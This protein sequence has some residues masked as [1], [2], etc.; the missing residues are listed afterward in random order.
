MLRRILYFFLLLLSSYACTKIAQKAKSRSWENET[1]QLFLLFFCWSGFMTHKLLMTDIHC[2]HFLRTFESF[3]LIGVKE[4]CGAVVKLENYQHM[5]NWNLG[6]QEIPPLKWN[7]YALLHKLFHAWLQ[8]WKN[9]HTQ[10]KKY[11]TLEMKIVQKL[12]RQTV[13]KMHPSRC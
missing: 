9:I 12:A 13:I 8:P 10:E 5:L 7:W 4:L 11:F 1:G 2:T 6:N 3:W